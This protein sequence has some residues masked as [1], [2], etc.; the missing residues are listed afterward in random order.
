[1]QVLPEEDQREGKPARVLTL[2]CSQLTRLSVMLG[3]TLRELH[4]LAGWPGA[5]SECVQGTSSY[6]YC[7]GF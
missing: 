4:E 3:A 6:I 5:V 2:Q 7:I 1:M